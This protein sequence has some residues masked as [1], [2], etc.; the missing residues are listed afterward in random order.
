MCERRSVEY[1]YAFDEKSLDEC[2]SLHWL[3]TTQPTSG[4]GVTAMGARYI[5]FCQA[6]RLMAG[7]A[8]RKSGR[9]R[10]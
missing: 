9:F 8:P 1:V 2:V 10:D 5:F 4:G 6:D 3:Q 7:T